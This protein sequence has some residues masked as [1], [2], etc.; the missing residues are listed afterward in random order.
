MK[1]D[2]K[3]KITSSVV[4]SV[5]TLGTLTV[6]MAELLN[7]ER[8]TFFNERNCHGFVMHVS[9]LMYKERTALPI[10]RSGNRDELKRRCKAEGF[11]HYKINCSMNSDS[12]T[13]VRDCIYNEY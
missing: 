1:F 7:A 9:S 3:N 6:G 4:A 11:S 10:S 2:Q 5:F 13:E 8:N 12:L